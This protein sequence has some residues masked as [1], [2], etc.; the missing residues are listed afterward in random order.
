MG[1]TG[2][3]SIG[4]INTS[5][6][7]TET[8]WCVMGCVVAKCSCGAAL[9]AP[10]HFAGQTGKCPRCGQAVKLPKVSSAE[11]TTPAPTPPPVP[12][13]PPAP[14]APTDRPSDAG[15]PQT[16]AALAAGQSSMPEEPSALSPP[17]E[18][19]RNRATARRPPQELS[20]GLS[21]RL[22]LPQTLLI[23]ACTAVG[24]FGAAFAANVLLNLIG[25]QEGTTI[26]SIFALAAL[27]AGL[28]GGIAVGLVLSGITKAHRGIVLTTVLA[29]SLGICLLIGIVSVAVD[30]TK[31]PATGS[32]ATNEATW[33]PGLPVPPEGKEQDK[34]ATLR[35]IA[36][37]AGEWES[38][39]GDSPNLSL[40]AGGSGVLSITFSDLDTGRGGFSIGVVKIE[41]E[42][43]RFFVN[44]SVTGELGGRQSFRFELIP[45][46][47]RTMRLKV[48]N[49]TTQREFT[50]KRASDKGKP[51][52]K[53]AK[54]KASSS[55]ASSYVG[56]LQ[57]GP[58]SARIGLVTHRRRG[59][60]PRGR[61]PKGL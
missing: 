25:V 10:E 15:P 24:F 6:K 51:A 55:P 4:P 18:G 9:K 31:V 50:L 42:G 5:G 35:H 60:T 48:V 12:V 41:E 30:K 53:E 1:N 33:T 22:W 43:A 32:A 54:W 47:G 16:S 27:A 14:L 28:I 20:V 56:R 8:N 49:S 45:L 7:T 2:L 46:D 52:Q 58:D 44:T 11:R 39:D 29:F 13:A 37:F 34:G 38:V 36:D 21:V 59:A 26:R 40:S 3:E 23:L 19:T 17:Y 61:N 57:G